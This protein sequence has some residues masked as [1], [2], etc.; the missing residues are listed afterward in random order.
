[1]RA[2]QRLYRTADGDLVAEG[3]LAAAFLAYAE[4]DEVD[5]EDRGKVPG[6]KSQAPRENKLADKPEDKAA[7]KPRGRK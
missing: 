6:V 7:P 3:N 4:G 2:S 1:M 5:A